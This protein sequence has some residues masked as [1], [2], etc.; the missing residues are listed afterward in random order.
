VVL[1][2]PHPAASRR[3]VP[4]FIE[5]ELGRTPLPALIRTLTV[6]LSTL[7]AMGAF[8]SVTL[9][10]GVRFFFPSIDRIHSRQEFPGII[11]PRL[12]A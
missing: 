12:L 10:I 8:S 1:L 6:L 4:F 2:T 9:V 5:A 7:F 3:S 11:L